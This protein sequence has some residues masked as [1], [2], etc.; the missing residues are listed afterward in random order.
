MGAARVCLPTLVS[1]LQRNAF[2]RKVNGAPGEGQV[3]NI[4]TRVYEEP[5]VTEKEM[6]LG[7]QPNSTYVAGVSREQRAIRLGH[8][9]DGSTMAWFGA[10]LHASNK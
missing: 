2:R 9:L 5:D 1:Y 6:P 10:F 7:F 4:H 3:F 8:A